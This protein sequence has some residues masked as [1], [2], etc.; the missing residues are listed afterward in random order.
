M[1]LQTTGITVETAAARLGLTVGR[2]RQLLAAGTLSGHKVSP[3][4]WLIDPASVAVYAAT[5]R[6]PGPKAVKNS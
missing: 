5:D 1:A 3:R 4:C 2:V 6:R